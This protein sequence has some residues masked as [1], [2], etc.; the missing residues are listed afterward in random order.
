METVENIPLIMQNNKPQETRKFHPMKFVTWLSM[1]ASGM[2]FMAFTSALIVSKADGVKNDAWMQFEMPMWFTVSTV[3]VILASVFMHLGYVFNKKGDKTKSVIFTALTMIVGLGFIYS[4]YL[5]YGDLVKEGVFFSNENADQI[6]GSYFY[7][8]T[9]AH[10]FHIL[11]G[12]LIL[13][14]TFIQLVRG[15]INAS[16]PIMMYVGTFYWHFLGFLWIYLFLLLNLT[17]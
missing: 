11:L 15:K 7:V 6:S 8:I 5:G 16:K 9:G 1:I 10:L 4:Q 12:L 3:I 14:Y 13:L 17:R 2:L